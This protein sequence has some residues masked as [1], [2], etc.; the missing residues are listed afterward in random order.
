MILDKARPLFDFSKNIVDSNLRRLGHPFKMTLAITD[1]CNSRCSLCRIWEKEA[2][3]ERSI[4][5]WEIFFKKNRFFNWIDLTGGEV[6]LYSKLL[7]L[8]EI[9]VKTQK[10]LYLLHIPTN[11]IL[12]DK[13]TKNVEKILELNPKLFLISIALDGSP[14]VHDKLRGV[15]GNW[16]KAVEAYKRL[17]K[18]KSSRFDCVFGMTLSGHNS[19][20]IERTFYYLKKEV[21]LLTRSDIHFNIAH[22]SSHYY[23]NK[24]IDLKIDQKIGEKLKQFRRKEKICISGVYLLEKAYQNLIAKYIKEG[25][26]PIP[27]KSLSVSIFIN[28]FGDVFPCAMWNKKIGNLRNY[29]FDLRKIWSS[30]KALDCL[31]IIAKKKCPNCWTPCEAYQSLLANLIMVPKVILSD[32]S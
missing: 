7:K 29:D 5:Y 28:P 23:K 3:H 16:K 4:K 1:R 22:H 10:N 24:D 8:I 2:P 30:Q 31:N 21:P 27:C 18:F 26:S 12:I 20:L 11:G 17:K 13:I 19:H 32:A 14:T 25:I 9:I 6:F 15:G